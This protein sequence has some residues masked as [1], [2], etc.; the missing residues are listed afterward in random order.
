ME[1]DL[2]VRGYCHQRF[3]PLFVCL[4]FFASFAGGDLRFRLVGEIST[5]RS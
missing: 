5:L 1:H 3:V 4:F 2:A